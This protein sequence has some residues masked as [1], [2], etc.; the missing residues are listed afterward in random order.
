[1]SQTAA[2]APKKKLP[3]VKLA[4]VA[5]MLVIGGVVLLRGVDLRAL[6]DSMMGAIRA[7]GPVVFFT[8]MAILP[9]FGCPVLAFGLTAGPA[10]S[11][12]LGMPTVV[13][14][15]LLSVTVNFLISY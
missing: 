1:M 9:A 13:G 14:L 10:F 8:A 11:E 2:P 4:I 15:V 7:Q 3:V 5:L 12:Q 6:M